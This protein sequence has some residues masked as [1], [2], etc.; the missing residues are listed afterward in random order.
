MQIFE[1]L[2]PL[3]VLFLRLSLGVIFGYSGYQKLFVTMAATL[4]DFQRMGLPLY[5]AYVAGVLELFGAILL[6]LGLL[7][8]VTALLLAVEMAIGLFKVH[9]PQ[10]GIYAV[11]NY[12]FPLALCAAAF[13]L[14]TFGAGLLSMD[15]MTFERAGKAR[16]KSRS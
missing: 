5:L 6:V 10:G 3:A 9:I 2:K 15:A 12:Q 1:K 14:A 7:T 16:P 13:A 4:G 8:R 11:P